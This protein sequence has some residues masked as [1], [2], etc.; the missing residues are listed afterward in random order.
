MKAIALTAVMFLMAG[1]ALAKDPP[2]YQK[3]VILQMESS[4]CGY[5]TKGG[6]SVAEQQIVAAAALHPGVR[7][8]LFDG[9]R[10]ELTCWRGCADRFVV[11]TD[12]GQGG[13]GIEADVTVLI[14]Q[15]GQE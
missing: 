10:V 8:T 11:R 4:S 3:G 15:R 9:K 13:D 14:V 7:L 12:T 2:V 5:N 1:I 6:K